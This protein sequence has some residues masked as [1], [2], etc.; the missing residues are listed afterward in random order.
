MFEHTANVHFLREHHSGLPHTI[1]KNAYSSRIT[2]CA[3]ARLGLRCYRASSHWF[4]WDRQSLYRL[5]ESWLCST[6]DCLSKASDVMQ[7][8]YL[9]SFQWQ[10]NV[11]GIMSR[12]SH[13]NMAHLRSIGFVQLPRLIAP[14][15]P[16]SLAPH[17]GLVFVQY[18]VCFQT[19]DAFS[20]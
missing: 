14:P 17:A 9:L 6:Q 7:A 20:T 18:G 4:L 2:K 5:P 10:A 15:G 3:S 11:A 13:L 1:S 19:T 16:Y 12:L 8:C